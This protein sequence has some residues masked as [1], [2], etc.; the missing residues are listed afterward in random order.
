MNETSVYRST[1]ECGHKFDKMQL[2][3]LH[4]NKGQVVKLGK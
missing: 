3:S 4:A 2:Q 1:G